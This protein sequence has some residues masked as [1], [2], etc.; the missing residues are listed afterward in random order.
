MRE[1]R[2][3][4]SKW[5][6]RCIL[7]AKHIS[8]WSKDP[9]TKCGAIA[10][11]P[12]HGQIISSGYNGFPRGAEDDDELY[13]NREFKLENVV[14]AEMNL[15]FNSSLSGVSLMN[16]TVYLW[17]LPPCNK[18]ATALA[19]CGIGR[20]VFSSAKEVPESWAESIK[21]GEMTLKRSGTIYQNFQRDFYPKTY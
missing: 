1:E 12:T 17:G 16:S 9:S 14:H 7:L 5:D 19:Q 2:E 18:C 21:M 10:I 15:I 13:L 4:E 11:N 20:I 8:G 3:V 6:E